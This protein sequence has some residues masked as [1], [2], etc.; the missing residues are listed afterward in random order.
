MFVPNRW[1]DGA[2]SLLLSVG[3]GYG[4]LINDGSIV[5][6]DFMVD[7]G[8]L[9][10]RNRENCLPLP[11]F[12]APDESPASIVTA[13]SPATM[14]IGHCRNKHYA[15]IK[16]TIEMMYFNCTPPDCPRSLA[17]KSMCE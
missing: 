5:S 17:L 8:T 6:I 11:G 1:T 2:A 14:L 13:T 10:V 16:P 12:I 7:S 4:Q 15:D 3:S 9:Q